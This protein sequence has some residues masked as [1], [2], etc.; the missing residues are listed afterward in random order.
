MTRV[1]AAVAEAR[2][3]V[4]LYGDPHAT[5]SLALD[6]SDVALPERGDLMERVERLR[7]R[8]ALLGRS[9]EIVECRAETALDTY[10]RQPF[11]DEDPLLRIAIDS[12]RRMVLAAHHGAVDG[13]GLLAVAGT[14]LGVDVR[15]GAKGIGSRSSRA[16][17]VRSSLARVGEAIVRPPLRLATGGPAVE[18]QQRA[19]AELASLRV[20]TATLTH[21]V[22]KAVADWNG[23][24]GASNRRLV[25]ALG[26]SRR[27]GSELRPDRSTAYARVRIAPELSRTDVRKVVDA[28]EPEPDF[29]VT[30]ASGVGTLATRV[31]RSRLGSTGLAS[32]LGRVQGVAGPTKIAFY[33]AVAGPRALAVGLVSTDAATTVTVRLGSGEFATGAAAALASTISR[34]ISTS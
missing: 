32:N 21:A 23:D 9:P 22:A 29:P 34:R 3:V 27:A 31:L 17:F 18:G 13:L 5:W 30:S 4:G 11:A 7:A 19:V 10:L 24:H 16:G 2:R 28:L 6:I 14:L 26:I 25:I 33:P 12:G 15:T 8:H 20:D 1:D